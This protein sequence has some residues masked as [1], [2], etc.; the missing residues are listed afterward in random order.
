MVLGKRKSRSGETFYERLKKRGL[1]LPGYKYL[2]PFNS[3]NNGEPT[4][5]SDRVAK[6]HDEGYNMLLKRGSNPYIEWNSAD[7]Q[8]HH[9]WGTDYGGRIAKSVFGIKKGLARIGFIKDTTKSKYKAT[10]KE[11]KKSYLRRANLEYG[12]GT[13]QNPL[14]H[15]F[16]N[17]RGSTKTSASIKTM[18]D[19]GGSGQ[20][21]GLRET[22]VDEVDVYNIQRGPPDYCFSTL[23]YIRWGHVSLSRWMDSLSYRMTSPYDVRIAQSSTDLNPDATGA[24]TVTTTSTTEP[25]GT[26]ETARWFNF[27]AG[28][29]NYY[30]VVSCRWWL[31]IE[32]LTG[33]PM[34]VHQF[35]SN[36]TAPPEGASNTDMML[37][38]DTKSY[39]LGAQYAAVTSGAVIESAEIPINNENYEN[40]N[41]TSANTNYEADNHVTRRGPSPVLQLHGEY[42][43]GDY[44]REIKSDSEVENWTA[45]TANPALSERLHFRIRPENEALS[46]TNTTVYDKT[47]RYKYMFRCEYLVEFKELQDGLRYPVT[48]QPLTVT[49]NNAYQGA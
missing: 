17:L 47:L 27:Y 40:G 33:E 18:A 26:N 16:Q 29:Y 30:H 43:T 19:G 3:L 10:F 12:Q 38:K 49:I 4:N 41:S 5:E 28:M 32:N 20:E 42:R 39:C 37:W 14:K 13:A 15:S 23:P 45:T 9:R 6:K 25:D 24:T 7:E 11:R 21:A 8:A 48:R 1:T 44:N 46:I 34:W 31:T 2:G 22:P 35:Y 36:L